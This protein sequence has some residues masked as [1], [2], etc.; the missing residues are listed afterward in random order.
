[1]S[2]VR[3]GLPLT[4]RELSVLQGLSQGATY[5]GLARRWGITEKGAQSAGHRIL[6]KL[7]ALNATHAVHLAHVAGLI[8]IDPDCGSPAAYHR[9]QR[10]GI[11]PDIKCRKA[12]AEQTRIKRAGS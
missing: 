9:H 12:R 3:F 11:T 7:G 6:V 1:V 5:G 4:E 8:G 10:R 2:R